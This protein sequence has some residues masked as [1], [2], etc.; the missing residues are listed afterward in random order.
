MKEKKL[1][2]LEETCKVQHVSLLT[3][4]LGCRGWVP[5]AFSNTEAP[6]R[7]PFRL[8]TAATCSRI[9]LHAIARV[10]RGNCMHRKARKRIKK[11][12]N[13]K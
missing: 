6:R 4:S 13:M 1:S 2:S 10:V 8:W 3:V 11:K 7:T 9:L 12:S 5:Q